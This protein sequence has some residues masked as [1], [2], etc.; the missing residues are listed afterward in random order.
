MAAGETHFVFYR[1]V[2]VS[3]GRDIISAALGLLT[4]ALVWLRGASGGDVT[5]A[6]LVRSLRLGRG[7][8]HDNLAG[9]KV[10]GNRV[11][12]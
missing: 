7:L 2:A 1:M 8:A 10:L 11:C 5:Q 6:R 4:V 3:T 12:H 9:V